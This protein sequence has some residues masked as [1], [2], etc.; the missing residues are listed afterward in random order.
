MSNHARPNAMR[1][2]TRWLAFALVL[3]LAA[4]WSAMATAQARKP[5]LIPGKKTLY[6][7]VLTR[8]GAAVALRPG[9]PGGETLDPF[10]P[11]YVYQRY[12]VDGSDKVFLEVVLR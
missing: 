5:L 4:L 1:P 10:T 3:S 11:L 8:P 12:P 9:M 6:E 2:A 7:R